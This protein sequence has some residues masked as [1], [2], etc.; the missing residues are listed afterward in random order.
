MTLGEQLCEQYYARHH[1]SAGIMQLLI[2]ALNAALWHQALPQTLADTS[3]TLAGLWGGRTV[4]IK[5]A[6]DGGGRQLL[7]RRKEA[8]QQ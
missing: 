4:E 1:V 7:S 8:H 6:Q 3:K 5:G 2:V